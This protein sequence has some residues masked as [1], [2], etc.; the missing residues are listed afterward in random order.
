MMKKNLFQLKQKKGVSIMVSYVLLI[1]LAISLS[2]GVFFYLKL[3][4]PSES[5][6]CPD[7]ISITI[8]EIKCSRNTLTSYVVD[9]TLTNRGLFTID[10]AYIKMGDADR[11]FK[12]S[13]YDPDGRLSSSCNSG[14]GLKPGESYCEILSVTGPIPS[15]SQEISVEPL[16]YIDNEPVLCPKSIAVIKTDCS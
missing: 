13:I 1:A 9:I 4:L 6:N 10:S 8:D 16:I 12:K 15:A 3:Y 5:P 2:I 14:L 11:I 7:D